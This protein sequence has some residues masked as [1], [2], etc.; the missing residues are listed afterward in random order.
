[1][2]IRTTSAE[3]RIL[4]PGWIFKPP[5]FLALRQNPFGL[6]RSTQAARRVFVDNLVSN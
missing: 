2:T 5:A 3:L 6:W 4:R 1:M